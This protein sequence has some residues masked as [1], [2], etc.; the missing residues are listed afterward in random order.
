MIWPES[1]GNNS[2]WLPLHLSSDNLVDPSQADWILTQI[3]VSRHI[4]S[5][6][7]QVELAWQKSGMM[8]KQSS[9]QNG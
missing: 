1:S 3:P 7:A 8:T 9:L 6:T 2:S 4:W 5:R